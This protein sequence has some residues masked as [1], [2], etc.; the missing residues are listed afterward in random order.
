MSTQPINPHLGSDQNYI[1]GPEVAQYFEKLG[2]FESVR[3]LKRKV[4]PSTIAPSHSSSSD[5]QSQYFAPVGL[6]DGAG[7]FRSA[8]IN[9][10]YEF[11]DLP[12]FPESEETIEV[13][14]FSPEKAHE[15]WMNWNSLPEDE[16]IPS[17]FLKFI[18]ETIK[19]SAA[20]QN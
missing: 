19:Y 3:G 2:L 13:I 9:E 18:L 5:I 10:I 20:D 4:S 14:G 12:V 6:I 7:L 8:H 15:I 17:E 11:I 1:V 16:K